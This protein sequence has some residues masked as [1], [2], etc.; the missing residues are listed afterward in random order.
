MV[1]TYVC[2]IISFYVPII[3][4]WNEVCGIGNHCLFSNI[5]GNVGS[6]YRC[7]FGRNDDTGEI[8]C[9]KHHI[10]NLDKNYEDS[11]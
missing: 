1:N 9:L 5:Y 2:V 4:A 3:Y 6:L 7:L 8:I 10:V 11:V